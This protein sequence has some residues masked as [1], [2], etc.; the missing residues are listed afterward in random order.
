MSSR[1]AIAVLVLA[2]WVLLGPVAMAFAGCAMMGAMCEGPCGTAA[3]AIV[4]PTLSGAPAIVSSLE[5]A[6]DRSLPANVLAGLYHPP[7]S[8]LR[9]A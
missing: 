4:A 3:C 7:K 6:P 9:S 5:V 1:G 8:L 2:V